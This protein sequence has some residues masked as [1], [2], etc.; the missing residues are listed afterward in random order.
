MFPGSANDLCA[1]DGRATALERAFIWMGTSFAEVRLW[2]NLI[3]YLEEQLRS[4]FTLQP[5]VAAARQRWAM[6]RDRFAVKH[7]QRS[8]NFRNYWKGLY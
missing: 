3:A 2:L 8:L 7:N 5:S 4:R 1:A 6:G